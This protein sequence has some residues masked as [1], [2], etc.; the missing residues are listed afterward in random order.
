MTGIF[1]KNIH[2]QYLKDIKRLYGVYRGLKLQK[3]ATN[4]SSTAVDENMYFL[5]LNLCQGPFTKHV[6]V[7]SSVADI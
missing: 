6:Y 5:L 1:S 3:S 4:F 2:Y 7:I